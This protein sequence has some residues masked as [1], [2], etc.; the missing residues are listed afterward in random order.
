MDK[1]LMEEGCVF[2][3]LNLWNEVSGKKRYPPTR[4]RSTPIMQRMVGNILFFIISLCPY[5][6]L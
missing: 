4:M 5:C 6:K 2:V 1:E 3:L